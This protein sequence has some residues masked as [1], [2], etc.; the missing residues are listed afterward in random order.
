MRA[1]STRREVDAP[2]SVDHADFTAAFVTGSHQVVIPFAFDATQTVVVLTN[3][4]V[5]DGIT[6][7]AG[8]TLFSGTQVSSIGAKRPGGQTCTFSGGAT[9]R[10]TDDNAQPVQ[11]QITFSGTAQALFP[12]SR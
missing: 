5:V 4:A 7:N 9:E 6:Y 10:F 12:N 1:P 3:G 8:D 2:A 11:V